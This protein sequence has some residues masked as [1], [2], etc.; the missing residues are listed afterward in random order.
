MQNGGNV[1]AVIAGASAVIIIAGC[2]PSTPPSPAIPEPYASG[3][4]LIEAMR[5]RY[6]GRWFRT[7][8]FVQTTTAF[9]PDGSPRNSVSYEAALLPSH[10]R[11]D[12]DPLSSGNGIL[13]RVDTT[14]LM[15]RGSI[16]RRLPR[17][18]GLLPTLFD[19][20]F[21]DPSATATSF[22]QHGYDLSRIRRDRWAGREVYVV[23]ATSPA[24]LQSPQ[25]WVD[26]EHMIMLRLVVPAAE[27]SP[28]TDI[29]LQN[30]KQ[31]GRVWIAPQVEY[32]RDGKLVS[33]DSYQHIRIEQPLDTALFNP[34]SWTTA[35]HWY[36]QR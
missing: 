30:Y 22:K 34:A 25:F 6:A 11:S 36:Q 19:V 21:L 20:Y 17:A 1:K 4:Q 23:G 28:A 8:T 27:T 32:Y 12:Y 31:V 2:K 5:N 26:R 15:Q 24:D 29:R 18:Y 16:L 35:R 3:E 7:V 14:Y 13:V 33:R 9:A 10:Q